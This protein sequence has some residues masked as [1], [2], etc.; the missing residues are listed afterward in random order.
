MKKTI[1]WS[2]PGFLGLAADWQ[3]LPSQALQGINPYAFPLSSLADW[4]RHFNIWMSEQTQ[5]PEILMG[6]S[7]GGRLALHALIDRPSQWKA[8]II[9]SAHPGLSEAKEREK[10]QARDQQWAQRFAQE[11]WTSLIHAWN[12]Q[13][14]FAQDTYCFERREVDYQREKL[15]HC[16][17]HGSLS[18]QEDL[19]QKIQQLTLPILWVTGGKDLIYNNL[20]Q[21]LSFSHPLSQWISIAHAGHRVPWS[22]PQVFI[23]FIYKFLNKL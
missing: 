8:A 5:A 12:Q 4:A 19:R 1:I 10:R 11:E 16:L 18:Q 9:V 7:M 3:L 20:A 21:T 13:E 2:I 17:T 15:V 22:Q 14:I 6:Y 23:D